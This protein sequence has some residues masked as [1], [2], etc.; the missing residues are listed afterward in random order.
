M[1]PSRRASESSRVLSGREAP[2]MIP[3]AVSARTSLTGYLAIEKLTI[4]H[5][6]R[7]WLRRRQGR[8]LEQPGDHERETPL[9]C[10]LGRR[11]G[12]TAWHGANQGDP[13]V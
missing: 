2:I 11:A 13:G 10:G 6:S 9:G 8:R 1:Y 7:P 4:A 12:V 3:A 5:G